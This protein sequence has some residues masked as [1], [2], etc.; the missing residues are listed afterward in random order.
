MRG[1]AIRWVLNA[2]ALLI[3]AWILPGISVNSFGAALVAA[4][5][6]GIVNAI[7]RPVVVLFTLPLNILTLGL[8][9]LVINALMLMIVNSVVKGF[10]ISG[11]WSAF[12]GSIILTVISGLLSAAVLDHS[13]RHR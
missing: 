2:V 10:V 13:G 3:T 7:V 6:L 11:F 12:F 8:F 1:L 9:T 5:V 4:L